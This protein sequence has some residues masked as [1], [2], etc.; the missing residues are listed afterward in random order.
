MIFIEKTKHK[1]QN[2]VQCKVFIELHILI[3]KGLAIETLH[4]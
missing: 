3:T 4:Y 2:D 1:D